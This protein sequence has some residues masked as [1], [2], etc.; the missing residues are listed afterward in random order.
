[1]NSLVNKVSHVEYLLSSENIDL[2]GISE[3]WLTQNTTDSYIDI[4]NYKIVRKDSPSGV[5]KHGVAVYIRNGLKFEEIPTNLDNAII[6][7]LHEQNM[8]VIT[9]YRPP[10]YDTATNERV[11]GF[12]R[13]FCESKEV[14][15]Q[16]DF[17]LPTLRWQRE[18]PAVGYVLPLDSKFLEFFTDAGLWQAVREPT[19]FPS[20]NIIDL[21]LLSHRD[22]LGDIR[23]KP[24]LPSCSHGVVLAS[25]LFQFDAPSLQTAETRLWTRGFY[26]KIAEK[27]GDF[28]WD[29]EFTGLNTQHMYSKLISTV[30][31][32]VENYV[33]KAGQGKSKPPWTLNPPRSLLQRKAQLFAQ[34]KEVR[35]TLNRSHPSTI[36]AWRLFTSAN[37]NIKQF[38]R[39]SQEEYEVT[40]ANQIKS[41]PKLFHS[42]LRHRRVGKPSIGP[43]KNGT[44]VT[45]DPST[46]AKIFVT[47]FERVFETNVPQHPAAHQSTP[48]QLPDLTVTS[49]SIEQQIKTLDMNSSMGIDGVHP[50]LL[51]RCAAS[52]SYP[53]KLI[54]NSSLREGRLPLEWLSSQITPI[55][56]KGSRTTALNYR[57]IAITSVPCKVLEKEIVN[58]LKE[59][60]EG[61]G[62]LSEHQFGFRSNHSTS[63]QL[64]LCYDEVTRHV[65]Q[66][67]M[68]DL[69]FFDYTK[70]FDKVCH[71]ILLEKLSSIGVG[72]QLR[73]WIESF[74]T[75]RR[76]QV[77]VHGAVSDWRRVTSGV[78]QGSALGP[79]LFLLYV[80]HVVHSL[81]CSYKIFADDIKL[82]LHSTPRD[83]STGVADLQADI[84]TLVTTSASWGL[85]M[86]VTKCTCLRL[87]PRALG[88]CS[89]GQSPY[90]IDGT[91][92]NYSGVYKDL[93]VKVDRNLK[94]HNHIRSTANTCNAL[95]TN[96]L[97]ST[98]CREHNF[99]INIYKTLIRPK[100]EYGST[101]W[102]LGYL[103]DLR[104][105]ER[106][107]R[108]WTRQI[109]G[110]EHLPYSQRL[111]H[112]DLFSVKGR[113]LRA[114]LIL[115]WKIFMGKCSINLGQIFQVR[116]SSGRGH[117]KKL[118]LPRTSLEVR[119]RFFPVRV[120]HHW[121]SLSEEAV[122]APTLSTFK[123]FL[124]RDL[125][126]ELF[127]YVE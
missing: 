43:L 23:V 45:D 121:N 93:G 58:H 96:L 18:G 59:H 80:N 114:D 1:M 60:L 99:L 91:N 102:N 77:R 5:R 87:G 53:L 65:D 90:T 44:G 98:I 16:G 120:V 69:I 57:P 88:D 125:G 48:I 73:R 38:A 95:T 94:F 119:R 19:N 86:N 71:K 28:D 89:N 115:T 33:P 29:F 26:S 126:Q 42:Y 8:Y 6:L 40:L 32:L 9:I 36:N 108:R 50:R 122:S 123:H 74:L 97:S 112:L 70:A 39:A 3:T 52:L 13:E 118:F 75:D 17:N 46:M 47:T 116:E 100:L 117:S 30:E 67:K 10:S 20:E 54:F 4:T 111:L 84:N 25:Y 104:A 85:E 51:T 7:K 79:T 82:Y 109:R 81:S 34:Y 78:P 83:P 105:L 49:L 106:V 127:N 11:I 103:G 12:L 37:N 2:L 113:L 14:L 24:P 61:N 22:R 41:S 15:L 72:V 55:F 64:I 124:H 56:K 68:V 76:M 27:L 101:V 31:K 62:L 35:R 92:I 107:Q 21:C 63:D 110:L 66:H